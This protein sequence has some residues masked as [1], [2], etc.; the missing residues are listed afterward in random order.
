MG[1]HRLFH[2]HVHGCV[3]HMCTAIDLTRSS[4]EPQPPP[5]PLKTSRT[6]KYNYLTSSTRA[7]HRIAI[8]TRG[9]ALHTER[10]HFHTHLY[11]YIYVSCVSFSEQPHTRNYYLLTHTH[12]RAPHWR[13]AKTRRADGSHTQSS[14][15]RPLFRLQLQLIPF[16]TP[17]TCIKYS[18]FRSSVYRQHTHTHG[19]T[20][21]C[22]LRLLKAMPGAA[23]ALDP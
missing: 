23:V 7:S 22:S 4:S 15:C 12:K 18:K 19:R 5:I 11:I 8:E 2:L 3:T 16:Q 21:S 13:I 20:H 14:I 1:G 9:C 6:F 10:R 17:A